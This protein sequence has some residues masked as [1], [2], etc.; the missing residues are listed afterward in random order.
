MSNFVWPIRVYYEDTDAGGVVY[1]GQYLNFMERAR[2]EWLRSFGYEQDQLRDELGILFAVRRVE[3][4]YLLPARF[5]EAL[6]VHT[7]VTQVKGASFTFDQQ[8]QRKED[9][10]LLCR[11]IVKV[12]CI[13]AEM[14]PAPIPKEI[15][16]KIQ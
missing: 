8:V 16:Q 7:Q 1:H 6:E 3:L 12:A 4:D 10:M 15:R 2:T 5:N 11:G 14:K 13:G 9:Q